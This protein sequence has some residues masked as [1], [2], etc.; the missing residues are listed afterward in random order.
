MSPAAKPLRRRRKP[1]LRTRTGVPLS[2]PKTAAGGARRGL[3][4]VGGGLGVG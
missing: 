2:L 3:V 4:G 1:L